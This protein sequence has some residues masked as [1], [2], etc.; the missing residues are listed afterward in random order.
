MTT[1]IEL[2]NIK[3]YAYHGVAEQERSVGNLFVVDILLTVPLEKAMQSDKLDDTINYAI[4]YD[5]VK[6]EM[7]IPSNLLEHVAGRIINSL[8]QHF[9]QLSAIELKVSK[10]NPPIEGDVY[11]ASV[12]VQQIY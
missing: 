1:R 8:K 2:K 9:S 11:S 12:I 4:V 7:N 10:L 3:L 5:I 6:L